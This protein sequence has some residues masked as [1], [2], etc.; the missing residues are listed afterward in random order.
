[1]ET[2]SGAI[3]WDMIERAAR[4]KHNVGEEY[5]L[6]KADLGS[7]TQGDIGRCAYRIVNR[8]S[9]HQYEGEIEYDPYVSSSN[10]NHSLG[11]PNRIIDEPRQLMALSDDE[12]TNA[13]LSDKYNK[14]NL[15]ELIRRTLK[16]TNEYKKAFEYE[17]YK[18]EETDTFLNRYN[19]SQRVCSNCKAD[20]GD[21]YL[22]CH[23]CG[24]KLE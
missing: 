8:T 23:I 1:M 17:I 6:T 10:L 9:N 13:L 12:L 21:S 24:K 5:V 15:R 7:P 14:A 4:E 2:K 22:H 20:L 16:V 19:Q 3:L 11:K 18:R